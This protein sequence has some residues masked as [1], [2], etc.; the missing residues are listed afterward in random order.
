MSRPRHQRSRTGRDR[1]NL[2]DPPILTANKTAGHTPR[3]DT[4]YTHVI[5]FRTSGP[6]LRPNA[7]TTVRRPSN[8]STSPRS[9]PR[10]QPAVGASPTPGPAVASRTVPPLNINDRITEG[11]AVYSPVEPDNLAAAVLALAGRDLALEPTPND[12]T[13][14]YLCRIAFTLAEVLD[15][16]DRNINPH[17]VAETYARQLKYGIETADAP[18]ILLTLNPIAWVPS[19]T[20][21]D[22]HRHCRDTIETALQPFLERILNQWIREGIL[23]ERH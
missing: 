8:S 15:D 20:V 3:L 14:R 17:T 16:T 1:C 6:R 23:N 19:G 10:P 5:H 18:N 13:I 4:N 9:R 2:A 11:F 22:I 7:A 21:T 12:T